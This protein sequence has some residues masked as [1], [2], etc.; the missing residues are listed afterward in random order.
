MLRDK[1]A[2]TN[3]TA[4]KDQQNECVWIL[5]RFGWFRTEDSHVIFSLLLVLLNQVV[6]VVRKVLEE[7][8]LFVNLQAKNAV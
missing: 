2:V 7:I 8:V 5:K 4:S 3:V 6:K 1:L